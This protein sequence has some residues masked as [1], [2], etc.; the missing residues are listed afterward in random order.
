MIDIAIAAG[1]AAGGFILGYLACALYLG[2]KL[3]ELEEQ[4]YLLELTQDRDSRG[5]F[6]KSMGKPKRG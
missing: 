6:V 2:G 3:E 1:F 5:R 4:I